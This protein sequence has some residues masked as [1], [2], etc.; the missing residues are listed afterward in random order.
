MKESLFAEIKNFKQDKK[1]LIP[2]LLV[3]GCIGIILPVVPG[4]VLLLLAL[5]LIFPRQGEG[6][7][8]RLRNAFG[9][10]SP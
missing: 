2:I 4:L 3:L 6:I 9:R 1:K 5:L 10:K 7:V 8:K